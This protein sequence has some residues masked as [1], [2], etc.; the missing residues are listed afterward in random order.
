MIK[1]A[2][3]GA[4]SVVFSKNLTGDILSF[5]EFKDATFSYM[6]IDEERLLSGKGLLSAPD[7]SERDAHSNGLNGS[8]NGVSKAITIDFKTP[9]E[10]AF[11]SDG[12]VDLNASYG[13][14]IAWKDAGNLVK[15]FANLGD[16]YGTLDNAVA[17]AYT[18][19]ES[20][21]G[22][23]TV[24][25]CGSD[26]GI[27]IWLNGKVVHSFDGA[28]GHQAGQDQAPIFLQAGVNRML[29]KITNITAGWG[30]SVQVPSANF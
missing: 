15:G 12:A 27:K 9:L 17:Y 26:D 20:I 8:S 24:L 14:G 3:I 22:R 30:F 19:I 5:P 29:V 11:S 16:I 21:H 13:D 7:D 1:V 4:G 25:K 2:M 6:D 28:R 18:E 10:D 23:E